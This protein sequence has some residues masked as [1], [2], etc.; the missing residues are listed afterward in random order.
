VVPDPVT[1]VPV[2]PVS[3]IVVCFDGEEHLPHSLA[4]ALA[5]EGP[6]AELV[7]VDNASRDGGVALAER[8]LAEARGRVGYPLRIE[9][10][11]RNDGPSPAR[12]RG[13]ELASSPRVLLLDVDA[14]APPRLVLDLAAALDADP[15]AVLAQPRSVLDH[16]PGRVHYDGGGFHYVGLVALRNFFTPLAE[17][18]G[19]GVLPVDCAIAVALLCE[20]DAVLDAGAFEAAYFVLYEDL[21]LSFRLRAAGRRILSVEHALCRHRSGTEGISFRSGTRYPVSRV[22]LHSRNRGLF[23]LRNLRTR[24]LVVCAPALCLYE[25]FAFALAL[26]SGGLGAWLAGKRDLLRLWGAARRARR[27]LEERRTVAD[28]EL[29]VG[30]PLSVTPA[31]LASPARRLVV[32]ALDRALAAWWAIVRPFAG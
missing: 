13:L 12:N 23:L 1:P 29:L 21:D 22:H 32:R 31:L 9:R 27:A 26:A 17:A 25:L 24:T 5:L 16:E 3:V 10:M 4:A 30:G 11:A 15:A 2:I 8:M 14:V 18:V 6:I 19:E 28:R 7:V 20:R